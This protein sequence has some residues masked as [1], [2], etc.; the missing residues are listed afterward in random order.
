MSPV[1]KLTLVLLTFCTLMLFTIR[2]NLNND[3]STQGVP[4]TN[5]IQQIYQVHQENMILEE[6]ILT[7]E[8]FIYLREAAEKIGFVPVKTYTFLH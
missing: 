3:L 2:E 1:N 7:V 8:S 5:L 6:K 4:Y